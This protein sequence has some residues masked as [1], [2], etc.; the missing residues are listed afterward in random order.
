MIF[1]KMNRVSY[2]NNYYIIIYI[3]FFNLDYYQKII[4]IVKETRI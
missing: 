2:L 3:Y 4:K 1:Y